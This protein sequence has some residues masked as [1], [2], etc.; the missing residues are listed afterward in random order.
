MEKYGFVYIW[1]D[2][3]RKMYYIGCHWGSVND[4]YICSSNRMRDAYRRRPEDFKRKIIITNIK[5]RNE[6]L[7]EEHKWFSFIKEEQLGKKYYN[8]RKHKW[9]HW[10][11]D[12]KTKLTIGQKISSSHKSNPNFGK[13][14]RGKILSEETKEKISNSTSIAMKK[15]YK[16]NLRNENTCK[17]ISENNKRL[18][19]EGKI[20][21][22]G[23][24]HS[25]ETKKL[26]SKNNAM[27]NPEHIQKIKEKKKGIRWL[28]NGEI[29]KMAVPGTDKY[30]DLINTGFY[31]I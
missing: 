27:N 12:E 16:E 15:Y 3:K 23:K 17:K 9:G 6:T 13:W 22:R 5:T 31:L 28:T 2:R 10:S 18:Q 8:L 11:T 30:T 29:K 24:T 7:E 19:K 20:G 25:I 1:Y 14:N 4:G 21:M 26:M